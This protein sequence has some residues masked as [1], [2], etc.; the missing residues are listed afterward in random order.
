MPNLCGTYIQENGGKMSKDDETALMWGS[1]TVMFGGLDT[2]SFLICFKNLSIETMRTVKSMSSALSFFLAMILNPR[3]QAK[4]QAELDA[5]VGKDRLPLIG[6][7]AD[8]PYI[9][10]IVA[11]VLRWAPA[12]PLGSLQILVPKNY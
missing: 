8:L 5:V 7:K 3:V 11:E 1:C 12:L 10:S 2:V 9:R 6:D 4:A